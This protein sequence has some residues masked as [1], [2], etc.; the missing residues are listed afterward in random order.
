MDNCLDEASNYSQVA[1]K[2]RGAFNC[3][4]DEAEEAGYRVP[5]IVLEELRPVGIV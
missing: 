4:A 1:L 3:F 2:N 5:G